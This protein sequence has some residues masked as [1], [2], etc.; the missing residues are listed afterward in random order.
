[1]ATETSAGMES[2]SVTRQITSRREQ[3]SMSAASSISSGMVRK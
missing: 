2:G 1:M 3:P